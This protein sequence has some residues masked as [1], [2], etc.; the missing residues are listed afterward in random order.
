MDKEPILSYKYG[1]V[2]P[3]APAIKG[4]LTSL[5]LCLVAEVSIE[6]SVKWSVIPSVYT[7]LILA[8]K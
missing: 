6:L 4:I 3:E 1:E 2:V 8:A 5:S 7:L